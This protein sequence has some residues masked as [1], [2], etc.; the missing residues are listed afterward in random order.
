[1]CGV[2]HQ[3]LMQWEVYAG[4]GSSGKGRW[5]AGIEQDDEGPFTLIF[6]DLLLFEHF[7][8]FLCSQ[9][10]F[11]LLK[12]CKMMTQDS[13]PYTHWCPFVGGAPSAFSKPPSG[14]WTACA[15]GGLSLPSSSPSSPE[16]FMEGFWLLVWRVWIW[17]QSIEVGTLSE[18]FIYLSHP[19]KLSQCEVAQLSRS[20]E[21]QGSTALESEA[22]R[23]KVSRSGQLGCLGTLLVSACFPFWF[24]LSWG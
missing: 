15:C 11:D 23:S 6:L 10:V 16:H 1:M 3:I 24:S 21:V 17:F 4:E 19:R 12:S 20:A 5:I 2:S 22:P 8:E 14:W 18:V 7:T 9:G 13:P